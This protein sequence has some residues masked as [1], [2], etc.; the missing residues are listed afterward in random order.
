[1]PVPHLPQ[2]PIRLFLPFDRPG[3]R[4]SA[5]RTGLE[6]V[7]SDAGPRGGRCVELNRL[8][9]PGDSIVKGAGKEE[10]VLTPSRP[11]I[12]RHEDP[13]AGLDDDKRVPRLRSVFRIERPVAV[14]GTGGYACAPAV[15]YASRRGIPTALQEQNVA[16]GLA[17]RLLGRRVRHIYLGAPEARPRLTLGPET[18]VFDTGNPITPPDF[19]RREAAIRRFAVPPGQPV[20]LITGG[21]Q[22]ALAINQAVAGWLEQGGG[23]AVTVLWATGKGSHERFA[24]FHRAPS[25]QVFDFLDP[26][27]DAYSV[28]DLVV[29]RAGMMTGAELCA[30]GLPS[31]LIPLPTAASDHQTTN[32]EALAEAGA[33]VVLPQ[34]DLTPTTFGQV[35]DRLLADGSL[36]AQMAEA[37]RRRGKPAAAAEIVSHLL[38]LC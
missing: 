3:R 31:V 5:I 2:P 11:T 27:A 34:R 35:V 30:W 18:Q 26:L 20:V 23:H 24:R 15:W 9:Q 38:T 32:A 33:A 28:S 21:S 1:M 22:G 25:V 17:T 8:R 16:P 6:P 7:K 13:T 19:S 37:A 29:G 14:L 4:D 12:V 36:R 10:A